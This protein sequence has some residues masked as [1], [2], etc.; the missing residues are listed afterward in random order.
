MYTQIDGESTVRIMCPPLQLNPEQLRPRGHRSGGGNRILE[1]GV[2]YLASGMSR[3]TSV[4]ALSGPRVW[5]RTPLRQATN[6]RHVR[7]GNQPARDHPAISAF[8]GTRRT[9]DRGGGDPLPPAEAL[10]KRHARTDATPIVATPATAHV[11][12]VHPLSSGRFTGRDNPHP[13]AEAHIARLEAMVAVGGSSSAART[14][15]APIL[16][17]YQRRGGRVNPIT[18]GVT[19]RDAG[20]TAGTMQQRPESP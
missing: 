2:E 16:L 17:D 13:P 10:R 11:L 1:P 8:S 19:P 7:G 14:L 4:A 5:W 15:R 3:H 20:R 18:P 12:I 6:G 9:S